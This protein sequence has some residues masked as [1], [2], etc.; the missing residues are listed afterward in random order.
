MESI[1]LLQGSPQKWHLWRGRGVGGAEKVRKMGRKEDGDKVGL[2]FVLFLF[3]YWR[4]IA[5]GQK[6]PLEEGMAT[7]TSILAWKNP[8]DRGAWQLGSQ[9]VRQD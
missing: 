3:Y 8:M 7:H 4:I 5:L 2:G 1:T 6:D 9:R